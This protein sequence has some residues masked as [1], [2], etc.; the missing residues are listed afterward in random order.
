MHVEDL[1]LE[2][3]EAVGGLTEHLAQRGEVSRAFFIS[4]SEG[5]RG[6]RRGRNS[7]F[8]YPSLKNFFHNCLITNDL[9]ATKGW[10]SP[11]Q[12]AFSTETCLSSCQPSIRRM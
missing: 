10:L 2:S 8:R 5:G 4:R 9:N 7:Y 11:L 3:T 12:A 1:P 6:P